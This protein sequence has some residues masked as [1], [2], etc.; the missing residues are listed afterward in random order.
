MKTI[1]VYPGRFQPFGPHH[2]KTYQWL[3]KTFGKSDVY[4][5][6]SNHTDMN[7][8]LNFKEKVQCIRKYAVLPTNIVQVK[9]PYQAHELLS[10]FDPNNTAVIFAYG[11]KDYDRIKF[12]KRDGTSSW[13]SRYYGQKDL[14]PMSQ[15]GYALQLPH[16]SISAGAD[17]NRE[18]VNGSYLRKTL[19]MATRTEF[20]HVM[21]YYDPDIHYMFKKKFHPDILGVD[22][23]IRTEISEQSVTPKKYSKHIMHP[24]ED[25]GMTWDDL[26]SFVSDVCSG[27][28]QG[29]VK[30][31]GYN[32]QVTYRNG[33]FKAARNKATVK[34]PMTRQELYD[35]YADKPLTQKVFTDAVD[36]VYNMCSGMPSNKLN[37]IFGGGKTF[38]NMEVMHPD[39]KNIFRTTEPQIYLHSLITYDELGNELSRDT[40][41]MLDINRYSGGAYKLG[42]STPVHISP[43]QSQ[44]IEYSVLAEIEKLQKLSGTTYV[45]D[46]PPDIMNML[47]NVIFRFGAIVI[48]D[49]CA[50]NVKDWS[51]TQS[52]TDV[53]SS[54]DYDGLADSQRETY[55]N[56]MVS[57]SRL[58]GKKLLAPI[59][60]LVIPWRGN[61][62]KLTGMFGLLVPILIGIYNK[63]RFTDES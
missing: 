29:S 24:F 32:L 51:P 31:D 1:V 10:Q 26:K 3:C 4:I 48:Y 22:D 46:C 14:R 2:F 19:P 28:V 7:S 56:C 13:F 52:I 9:V 49:Y 37:S 39:N 60:G 21:G 12:S 63:K 5:V 20:A 35:K 18:E 50:D 58:G 25:V 53:I 61:T 41:T 43:K 62:Y 47:K 57:F 17:N 34:Y 54:V 36:V 27:A 45:K 40:D 33:E 11:S 55:D 42:Y 23:E 15:I 59:E 8:P 44:D 30:Q 6:T 16:V 38:L